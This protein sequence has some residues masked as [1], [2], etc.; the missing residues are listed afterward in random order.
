MGLVGSVL[1]SNFDVL[2][3]MSM[4]TLDVCVFVHM[5]GLNAVVYELSYSIWMSELSQTKLNLS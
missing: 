4:F 2:T 1:S 5:L 3:Y